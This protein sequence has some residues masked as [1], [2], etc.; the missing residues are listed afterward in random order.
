MNIPDGIAK[1]MHTLYPLILLKFGDFKKGKFEL[2]EKKT[3]L[4]GG[5][6][7]CNGY[8]IYADLEHYND[9][10]LNKGIHLWSVRSVA[11]NSGFCF[12][13]IGVTTEKSNTLI[14]EYAHNGDGN[15][16]RWID[17]GYFSFYYGGQRKWKGDTVVTV[18]LDC[19]N[20][21]VTY[22]KDKTEI[23]KDEIEPNKSYY[24][25]LMCCNFEAYTNLEVAENPD[26]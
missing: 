5:N 7:D 11:R 22:Y 4:K 3:S 2:N 15:K 10:G 13:S 17:Q 23:Q 12:L 26:V 8:L 19:V 20:W 25:A 16:I 21:S 24:F 6:F 9:I 1:I 14:D 18:K